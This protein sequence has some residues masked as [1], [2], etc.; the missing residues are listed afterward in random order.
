MPTMKRISPIRPNAEITKATNEKAN[1]TE[2]KS[3]PMRLV[4][5][6]TDVNTKRRAPMPP[7]LLLNPS[8]IYGCTQ[9]NV[10][11]L[12]DKFCATALLPILHMSFKMAEKQGKSAFITE[13]KSLGEKRETIN[14]NAIL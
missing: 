9:T 5:E 4:N 3:I 6:K 8:D 1:A 2:G 14:I 12:R 10:V 13:T 7:R 11:V